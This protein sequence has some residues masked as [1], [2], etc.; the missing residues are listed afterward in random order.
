MVIFLDIDG[1]LNSLNSMKS[2]DWISALD[3][4]NWERPALDALQ[5]IVDETGADIVISSTW[6]KHQPDPTWWN[7]QF[8]LAG[9]RAE[10]IGTTGDAFNGFRGRE[11]FH[12]VLA[13]DIDKF[14]ILDDDR[15]FYKGQPFLHVSMD[16]G[17]T[18]E[19]ARVASAFLRGLEELP[20]V[21]LIEEVIR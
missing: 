7:E 5:R 14:I 21:E 3:H 4:T 16:T 20:E 11:I 1:V 2:G 9:L 15:D 19:D 17:L 10:C 18:M 6:R 8:E 12:Y 13:N